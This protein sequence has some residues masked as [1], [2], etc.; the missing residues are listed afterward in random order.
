MSDRTTAGQEPGQ[1]AAEPF[2]RARLAELV[3][4]ER[5]AYRARH[6]RSAAAFADASAHLLGGVPMT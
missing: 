6:P 3:S 5:D 4:R 2:S 1:P